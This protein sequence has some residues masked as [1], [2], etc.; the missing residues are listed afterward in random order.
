MHMLTRRLQ[1]LVDDD[2]YERLARESERTGA[3]VGELV[4]RA[5]DHEFPQVGSRRG[6]RERA[7]RELLAMPPPPGPE[8][9]WEEQKREMLDAPMRKWA[10]A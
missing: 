1:V 6:E 4:R 9:D 5:I 2:R 10:G 8:P 7:G 3:P